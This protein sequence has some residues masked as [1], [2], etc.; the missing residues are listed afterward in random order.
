MTHDILSSIAEFWRGH[1]TVAGIAGVTLVV[2]ATSYV[3]GEKKTTTNL[4]PRLSETIP[5][6]TN[7]FQLI[8]DRGGLCSR[9]RFV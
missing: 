2:I 9:A 8:T 5:F 4:P 6:F 7:S 1:T 3:F